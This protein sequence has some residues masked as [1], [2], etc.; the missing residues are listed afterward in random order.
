MSSTLSMVRPTKDLDGASV[1][2]RIGALDLR[3]AP[4]LRDEILDAMANKC[5]VALDVT[6]VT[7]IDTGIVQVLL[8]ARRSAEQAGRDFSI[9]AEAG[10]FLPDTLSRLGITPAHT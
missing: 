1:I 3:N 2:T 9:I 7:S 5:S 8:A 6:Q 10:S 4:E